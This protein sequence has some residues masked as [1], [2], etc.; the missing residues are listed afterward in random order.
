MTDEIVN[1]EAEVINEEVADT[2]VIEAEVS[3]EELS[4]DSENGEEEAET[5]DESVEAGESSEDG[6]EAVETEEMAEVTPEIE[7]FAEV[8]LH[9]IKDVELFEV[10][11]RN[12][13]KISEETINE[14]VKNT[15]DMVDNENHRIP[16]KLGHSYAQ[17]IAKALFGEYADDWD[18]E[19]IAGDMPALGWV[20]NVRKVGK[21][22]IGDLVDIPQKLKTLIDNK[23]YGP[24]SVE[25]HNHFT[26]AEGV[27]IGKTLWALALLGAANPAVPS[28]ADLFSAGHQAENNIEICSCKSDEVEEM[29]GK[30]MTE[31]KV[32]KKIDLKSFANEA[33]IESKILELSA[34][35]DEGVSA[36]TELETFK[37]DVKAKE[38]ANFIE[39]LKE[40]GR[41]LPKHEG[42]VKAMLMQ[43]NETVEF[44]Y[45]DSQLE[46]NKK[47]DLRS[48]LMSFL[49]SQPKVAYFEDLSKQADLLTDENEDLD[50]LATAYAKEN[51]VGYEEAM[52]E[53]AA[54]KP[55]VL[56][57]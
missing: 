33:E 14:I 35:A 7:T 47:S 46:V 39:R 36:V 20:V 50:A 12:G 17:A 48:L 56:K 23:S 27:D 49:E 57:D 16:I 29:G 38:D 37:A 1:E 55:Q 24:R 31:E 3:D 40:K 2:E 51:K 15:A 34:K 52:F 6:E 10:G 42:T 44:E 28:L 13:I 5:A 4:N 11:I 32:E 53:V 9:E 22:I 19:M 18:T 45:F 21:K 43:A 30:Q 8:E 26:N 25:I 41:L 54:Q